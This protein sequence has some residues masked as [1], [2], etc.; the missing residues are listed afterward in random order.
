MSVKLVP[1]SSNDDDKLYD[2]TVEFTV[3]DEE[4]VPLNAMGFQLLPGVGVTLVMSWIN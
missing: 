4:T 1:E 2:C 3:S